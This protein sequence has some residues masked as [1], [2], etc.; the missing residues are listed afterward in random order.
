MEPLLRGEEIPEIDLYDLTRPVLFFPVRHHSPVCSFHLK[1]AIEEFK[2]Q[3]I[4]IEGPANAEDM[5]PVLT[6]EDTKAPLALYYFYKDQKGLLSGEKEDYKCYYPFLDYSPELLALR[7]AG[8]RKIPAHFMDL[9]YGEILLGTKESRGIRKNQ[10]KQTYNDDYLLS[11]SK[12]LELLCEKTGLRSFDEF[13]EKYFEIGG[14]SLKTGE[15]VR[16]MFT[17]CTLSRQHTPKEEMEE[18]GCLLRERYM[19]EQIG[20]MSGQ[21]GR[22]LVVTGGFHTY[23]LME[24]LG[25]AGERGAD[26]R[27]GKAGACKAG[28]LYSHGGPVSLH[29]LSAEEQGVYPLAYSMEA[30]DALNGYA[31]GMQSPGF[32][33][34]VWESLQEQEK[35][36]GAY[37]NAVLHQLVSAGRQ[38]RRQK[39]ALSS[40]D[41]ICALS[42]AK[43]L[44]ALRDKREPGLYELRDAAL[45]SFVKGEWS[46]S[47]DLPLRLLQELNTGKQV[48]ALCADAKRPPLLSDFEEQCRKF[49]LK[50][51]AASR[52]EVMLEL[53]TRKKHLAM[54]RFFYQMDFLGTDFAKRKKGSDLLNRKDKSRVRE[55]WI[56]RFSSQVLAALVD[57]SMS[58]GTVEEASRT[59]LFR[60]F[61][62]SRTS[63]EAARLMT[64]GFLMGFLEEQA[65]MGRHM[66][67]ILAGDG[68]FLSLTEGFSYLKMLYELQ[69]LYQVKDEAELSAL[70]NICFQKILQLLPSMAQIKEEQLEPCMETLRA[71]YQTT[72]D[73]KF[74]HL[75]PL[76]LDA[77]ERLLDSPKLNP[78]LEGTALGLLYGYDAGYGDRIQRTAAGY[79]QG[80][81]EM[82]M[83][84]A[85][86]LRGLF[87]TAKDLLFVQ[88]HFLGMIDRL[89]GELSPEAFMR[90]LPELR[91]AFGYFTPLET[92]RIAGK[93]A[94]LH[95]AKKQKI[96]RGR[97]VSPL[98]YAYGESLDAFA[99][100]RIEG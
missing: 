58:G 84:S 80:T 44:A 54:S 5:I 47:T 59:C 90:L 92:D 49:G 67:E 61:R 39:E 21:Y 28:P 15:F 23:G 83:N 42:M 72:G 48:G 34:K 53:F 100:K 62:K 13:W 57:Q 3:C 40:Y 27:P 88:E 32:Y 14:L 89:L 97:T 45:S 85:L 19:A 74:A 65:G 35:P 93:A 2:P 30:A 73:R 71:L 75:R 95:G 96:L 18:D 77:Y 86:F 82:Q 43:G 56:Y 52:Q 29:R 87:F 7:E 55:L 68:D 66:E 94:G 81:K 76:L 12:Y 26:E 4:L 24:L 78:G 10:E 64:Q 25:I 8:K 60:Q 63:R 6:H 69:E 33:Q 31:S 36:D 46:P 37:E 51:Q 91:R 20:K 41:V 79:L 70:I 99:R 98:E 16:R 50:I 22:I 11:R 17:Y 38:A 1:K 9:P